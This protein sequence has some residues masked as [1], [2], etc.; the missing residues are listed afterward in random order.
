[1]TSWIDRQCRHAAAAMLRSVSPVGMLK[2][3][4]GFGQVVRPRPGAIVASP[5]PGD[6]NPEPDYFFHWFRDAAIVVDALRLIHEDGTLGS[7]AF[8]H[9]ADFVRFT[10]SLRA[11]DGR[12]LV[13]APEWRGAVAPAFD[14]YV[15][16]DDE[17][18][19]VHGDAVFAETRVNPDGTL[20]VSRWGRPQHDGPALTALA[21]LR[22]ARGGATFDAALEADVTTLLDTVLAFTLDRW[23]EP[24]LDIWEE[25]FGRHY[26][27]LRVQAAAL[28]EGAA[29]RDER[30]EA[31]EAERY[32]E[33]AGHILR[34]LDGFWR[35]DAGIYESRRLAAGG[36]S[37]RNCDKACDIAV[38]LAA[39]H[40]GD[41]SGAHSVADEKTHRTLERLERMFA[42]DFAINRARAPG[43]APAMGRY[44]GDVYQSGG[45]WYLATL[46]C[47]ELCYSAAVA[48]EPGRA[49]ALLAHGDA[50]LA[51]VQA[52][53]P[54]SG[55]LAEQI[56][57][58]SGEQ[59]STKHLAWSY[60][61]FISCIASRRLLIDDREQT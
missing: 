61:A 42:A 11:L 23:R 55:D 52:F 46:G 24:C 26:Y 27:T 8:A 21:V 39:V 56:D 41:L 51:T 12:I 2:A 20:D 54:P 33:A 59:R 37:A 32:R 5:V 43:L 13:A 17:L 22:W 7:D 31:A 53:T 10:L 36:P 14:G 44:H 45:A 47:A 50:F 3:R 9:F 16:P 30:G 34:Q 6:W 35:E 4:P 38:I 57:P 60:A 28:A 1:M 19:G 29:W 40:A 49:S 58:T 15:R 25:E 18:A 48:A